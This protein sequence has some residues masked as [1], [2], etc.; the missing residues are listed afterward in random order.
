MHF[1]PDP[2]KAY[3]FCTEIVFFTFNRKS[4][5]T[6]ICWQLMIVI[7]SLKRFYLR[8]IMKEFLLVIHP[9]KNW[10]PFKVSGRELHLQARHAGPLLHPVPS[11]LPARHAGHILHP[12]PSRLQARHDG[13]LRQCPSWLRGQCNLVR[14]IRFINHSLLSEQK[15]Y[16]PV[17]Q[18][19]VEA[20]RQ[21]VKDK[22]EWRTLVHM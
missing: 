6:N 5:E 18:M 9:M 10:S 7:L 22:K 4:L 19:A 13:P 12:V 20:A 11:H 21:Y 14:L 2:I 16:H 1:L 8:W 3:I 17:W 15:G